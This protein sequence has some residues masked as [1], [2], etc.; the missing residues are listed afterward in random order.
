MKRMLTLVIASVLALGL[1][2]TAMGEGSP[3]QRARAFVDALDNCP[4]VEEKDNQIGFGIDCIEKDGDDYIVYWTSTNDMIRKNSGNMAYAFSQ[5]TFYDPEDYTK[6]YQGFTVENG[7]LNVNFHAGESISYDHVR[8]SFPTPSSVVYMYFAGA[9]DAP[10]ELYTVPLFY[11][12]ILDDQPR[13][14]E[15]TPRAANGLFDPE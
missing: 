7:K 8:I 14:L 2:S 9:V 11:T 4:L 15:D 5:I 1:V 6:S 10:K 13:V 3:E 12:L